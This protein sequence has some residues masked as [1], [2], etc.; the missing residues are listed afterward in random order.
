MNKN[1]KELFIIIKKLKNKNYKIKTEEVK[2][3]NLVILT[4][5]MNM[6]LSI[7]ILMMSSLMNLSR[8]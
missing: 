7:S 2:S 5:A 1:F 6:K 4:M 3:P 8:L